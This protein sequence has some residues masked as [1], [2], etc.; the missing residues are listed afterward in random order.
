[1][2]GGYE[3]KKL[4]TVDLQDAL[5]LV[6]EV[7]LEFE[8]P[9]YSDEG[10]REFRDFIE[11]SAITDMQAKAE[12]LLWGY[13]DADKLVGVIAT[14]PPCHISLLFVDKNYHRK[15]IARALY[16]TALD[17]YKTNSEHVAVT[18]NSSPYA[19]EAYR[20]LGFAD[21]DTEQVV[22]GIRFIPMKHIFR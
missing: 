17:Y 2:T 18:V 20:R 8:A 4:Q 11:L 5:R 10:I 7:F 15:G 1:M 21:T 13:F 19:A 14:K 16:H 22:N 12:L 3:L 9:E 6:W